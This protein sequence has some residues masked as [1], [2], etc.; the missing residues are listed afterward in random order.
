[1]QFIN[2]YTQL[3]T[4]HQQ[5]HTIT[6]KSSTITHKSS[7][8][9]HKSSTITYNYIQLHTITYNLKKLNLLSILFLKPKTAKISNQLRK[10]GLVPTR[11]IA[12]SNDLP[13]NSSTIT[14]NYTNHQQLHTITQIINNY[15]Q[16]HTI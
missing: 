16:L 10:S 15:I 3:H 9:T 4:N 8:I 2:N 13:C 6:H 12:I 5:L 14:H 7:T 1:M 11:A